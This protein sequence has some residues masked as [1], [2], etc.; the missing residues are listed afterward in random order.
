[1]EKGS[2]KP[3]PYVAE[4]VMRTEKRREMKEASTKPA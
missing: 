1:M 2:S 4:E 3:A